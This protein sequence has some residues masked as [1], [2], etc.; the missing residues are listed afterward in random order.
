VESTADSKTI[1][2][3]L[4]EGPPPPYPSCP[5]WMNTLHTFAVKYGLKR[6]QE[7]IETLAESKKCSLT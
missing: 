5:I 2:V 6:L 4:I 3:T 7:E 1:T